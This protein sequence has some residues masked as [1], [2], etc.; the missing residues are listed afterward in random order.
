MKK[1]CAILLLFTICF[2]F[3]SCKKQEELVEYIEEGRVLYNGIIYEEYNNDE[4]FFP[5]LGNRSLARDPIM[6]DKEHAVDSKDKNTNFLYSMFLLGNTVYLKKGVVIPEKISDA[7]KINKIE[8]ELVSVNDPAENTITD[9]DSI[10]EIV[11]YFS[12]LELKSSVE[13]SRP[14]DF[15]KIYGES[16]EYGGAFCLNYDQIIRYENGKCYIVLASGD[17]ELPEKINSLITTG[18]ERIEE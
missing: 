14:Y 3:A 13:Y 1:F 16:N 6:I 12:E 17:V 10:K 4:T 11:K 9:S 7:D 8:V 15:I 18:L 2:S 5:F